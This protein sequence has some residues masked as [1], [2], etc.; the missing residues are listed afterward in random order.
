MNRTILIITHLFLFII[1]QSAFCN[2]QLQLEIKYPKKYQKLYDSVSEYYNKKEF[3]KLF[4]RINYLRQERPKPKQVGN[5]LIKKVCK[6]LIT[7]KRLNDGIV[8]F[9]KYEN[10]FETVKVTNRVQSTDI[11]AI[12]NWASNLGKYTGN[13]KTINVFSHNYFFKH[14]KISE[15]AFINLKE[16]LIYSKKLN[17]NI[18]EQKGSHEGAI[19]IPQFLPK[20]L[21]YAIDGNDDDVI[22]INEIPDSIISVANY[23]NSHSYNTRGRKYAIQQYNKSVIYRKCIIKYSNQLNQMINKDKV[24]N[25]NMKQRLKNLQKNVKNKKAQTLQTIIKEFFDSPYGNI[26]EYDINHEASKSYIP[27]S[28]SGSTNRKRCDET[29]KWFEEKYTTN[30]VKSCS[31]SICKKY[32]ILCPIDC[33][34][35]SRRFFDSIE[36]DD[37]IGSV[38]SSLPETLPFYIRNDTDCILGEGYATKK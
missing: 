3:D 29:P 6:K 5:R 35:I 30:I 20:S 9:K 23:L 25:F 12:L 28:Q 27:I 26:I 13:I 8:F 19:G 21:K 17:I 15:K 34:T 2:N 37:D 32:K 18:Y 33:Y 22:D 16:L 14:G 24:S 1:V 10:F 7:N 36:N 31:I 38:C 4:L 11:I